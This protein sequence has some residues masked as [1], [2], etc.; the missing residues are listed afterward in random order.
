MKIV[1]S[2]K[3]RGYI[4]P[5]S[6]GSHMDLRELP[7]YQYDAN[8]SLIRCRPKHALECD[9]ANGQHFAKKQSQS[10]L[11]QLWKK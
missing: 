5:T 4:G 10:S 7:G 8:D 6:N 11:M 3:K 1:E 9:K 2:F